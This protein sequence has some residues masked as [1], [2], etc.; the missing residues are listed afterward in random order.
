MD[1]QAWFLALQVIATANPKTCHA[2]VSRW[3][4]A[5]FSADESERAALRRWMVGA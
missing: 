2:W 5:V 4:L 3:A 1:W